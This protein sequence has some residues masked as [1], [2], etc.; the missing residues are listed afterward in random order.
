MKKLPLVFAIVTLAVKLSAQ[1]N[2][3]VRLA[4]IAETTE[5]AMASDILTAQLSTNSQIQLL[6][7]NEI[8]KIY[9][10]QGLSAMNPDYLKLGHILGADGLLILR[11]TKEADLQRLSVR[12]LAVKPGVTLW[13]KEYPWPL[14]NPS[15]WGGVAILQ[16]QP[17]F[18]KLAVVPK[19]AVPI[20]ILNLRSALDSVQEVTLERELTELL[21][22][23]LINEKNIFVLER[24]RMDLLTE[25]NQLDETAENAFW[26]GSYLLEGVID[27]A[28]Y[29]KDVVTVEARLMPPDRKE[30]FFVEVSGA[31]TNL[32]GVVNDL[33]ARILIAL[34][35]EG[36]SAKWNPQAE[37]DRYFAEAQ[38]MLKWGMFQEAKSAG[39]ATWALGNQHRQVAELRIKAYQACAGDPGDCIVFNNEMRVVFGQQINPRIVDFSQVA[40]YASAPDPEQFADLV[41]AEELFQYTFR[42]SVAQ[43]ETLDPAWLSLGETILSQTSLWL[44]YYYFAAEARSGQEAT[45]EEAKTLCRTIAGMMENCPGF[46]DTDTNHTLLMVKARDAAFWVD[47]PE[48]CLPIYRAIVEA[49]Q[50]PLVRQRFLNAAY[51]EV[52]PQLERQGYTRV[53][54]SDG[55]GS[56]DSNDSQELQANLANP[57]LTGWAW[58]DRKRCPAVW[59]GFINELCSSSQPLTSL[60]GQILR[61]S[62]SWS[63]ADFER[64]LNQL[65]GIVRQQRDLI[66]AADLD[67][68]LL[69]D[70]RTLVNLRTEALTKKCRARVDDQIWPDFQ[71]VFAGLKTQY[72]D[73][74]ER[75]ARLAML[76]KQKDYLNTQTNFDFMSFAQVLSIQD[77]RPE[78]ARELLPYVTNYA[79]RV[80]NKQSVDNGNRM[81]LMQR[82][83]EQEQAKYWIGSLED[84]LNKI[85]SPAPLETNAP[86]SP[87]TVQANSPVTEAGIP[88]TSAIHHATAP[89]NFAT[90]SRVGRPVNIG[91]FWTIPTPDGIEDNSWGSMASYTY[92]GNEYCPQIASCCYR[93]GKLWVEVRYDQFGF[94]GRADF[95]GIDL[96]TFTA[97]KVEFDGEDGSLP[98]ALYGN[99]SHTFEVLGSFLYLSL[100]NSI[101]RYSLQDHSWEQFSVPASGEITPIRLGN[102]LYFTTSTSILEY[103]ADGSFQTLASSRRHPPVT[104]LDGVDNYGA[105]QL[106]LA[107]DGRLHAH[108]GDAVYVFLTESNNWFQLATRLEP[109]NSKYHPS[110]DGFITL[111]GQSPGEWWGMF[112]HMPAPESLFRQPP[113]PG[114]ILNGFRP[115]IP[116][117]TRWQLD[118]PG[119]VFCIQGDNIWFLTGSP[120]FQADASRHIQ[121]V[122]DP[123]TSL[124]CFTSGEKQP[125]TIPVKFESGG[126]TLMPAAVG[127]LTNPSI[128]PWEPKWTLQWTP[129]GLVMIAHAPLPGFWLVPPRDLLTAT[130]GTDLQQRFKFDAVDALH[131]Q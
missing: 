23:R 33:A 105:P 130:A 51:K 13:Q 30:G 102:H 118:I 52:S 4:L 14:D 119:Q 16:V 18:F 88:A 9:R 126:T 103:T 106:F 59:N 116:V 38:W 108:V 35:K 95:F 107:N 86:A 41:R 65:L 55:M 54:A 93:D 1:S 131:K 31:R 5:V 128:P 69:D 94:T 60:E 34:K 8:E 46:A 53:E 45:I 61:C 80:V 92:N 75:R 44:R 37:A 96:E 81:A 123:K 127:M 43:G 67:G 63:E 42:S 114:L 74:E 25:E 49:G 40:A 6:E 48:Q 115:T 91:R 99:H 22:A 62:Y 27:K 28:G 66:A 109:D 125:I 101:K 71:S 87:H 24:R 129:Q 26:N 83:A 77:Y 98:N 50:W 57:C 19:E 89:S 39:E 117:Q 68:P 82:K 12:L 124:V 10:E 20:S 84:K 70:L 58:M 11:P 15:Q 112:S 2:Q 7:R 47:T 21:Y 111:S 122:N 72:G 100:G 121:V 56:S 90:T 104:I 78:E 36:S 97:E 17:L 3:P 29:Q 79:A 113:S 73:P 85:I 76:E 64:N 120:R 32:Q 110:D